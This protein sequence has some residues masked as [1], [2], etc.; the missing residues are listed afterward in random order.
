MLLRVT[1]GIE[2]SLL[3]FSD[4]VLLRVAGIWNDNE[5]LNRF[6]VRDT[7]PL[8]VLEEVDGLPTGRCHCEVGLDAKVRAIDHDAVRVFFV[9]ENLGE[10]K[11]VD[12]AAWGTTAPVGGVVEI[13]LLH[14]VGK[15]EGERRGGHGV[16]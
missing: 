3:P 15:L 1:G 7:I 6:G 12:V 16:R 9:G 13:D 8:V 5:N 2:S 11:V 4:D 10:G 14:Q